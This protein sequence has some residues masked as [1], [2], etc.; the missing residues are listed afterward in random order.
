MYRGRCGVEGQL[1]VSRSIGDAMLK[2]FI[3]SKPDI[4]EVLL[5][6]EDRF[7]VLATDGLCDVLRNEEVAE[8]ILTYFKEENYTNHTYENKIKNVSGKLCNWAWYVFVII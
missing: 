6:K 2:P 8:L 1:S 3:S 4:C 5:T 7:V